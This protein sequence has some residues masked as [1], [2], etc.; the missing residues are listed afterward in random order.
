MR[1]LFG[2]NRRRP[3]SGDSSAGAHF[4]IESGGS[5]DLEIPSSEVCEFGALGFL[6]LFA[7]VVLA[8]LLVFLLVPWG[9]VFGVG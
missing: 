5:L 1:N 2:M 7:A 4:K 8:L 6:I 3:T 9:G